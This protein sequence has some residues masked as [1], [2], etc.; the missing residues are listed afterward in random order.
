[1]TYRKVKRDTRRIKNGF[2]IEDNIEFGTD[3]NNTNLFGR[4]Y[5]FG[6][7]DEISQRQS[8]F[9]F[10]KGFAKDPYLVVPYDY[11]SINKK[12]I[13]NP[14]F[15][16]NPNVEKIIPFE[17]GQQLKKF[18]AQKYLHELNLYGRL[19]PFKIKPN[20]FE[21]N[22]NV[23]EEED[24]SE[25]INTNDSLAY[26]EELQRLLASL[27][28]QPPSDTK[29]SNVLMSPDNE[30]DQP[31]KEDLSTK[32]SVV[33]V[34]A[35]VATADNNQVCNETKKQA[36][37]VKVDSV[38]NSMQLASDR[39]IS[40]DVVNSYVHKT[41][42]KFIKYDGRADIHCCDYESD[43]VVIV[44][45]NGEDDDNFNVDEFNNRLRNK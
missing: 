24:F 10:I 31:M 37:K 33:K 1:M 2:G 4:S 34:E 30:V 39:S 20:S 26:V 3:R 32:M 16:L 9:Y 15:R 21:E 8:Y 45:K 11:D 14:T 36:S 38:L 23:K 43:G 12:S 27:S 5:L 25:S 6:K 44:R 22:I 35:A 13:D 7:N 42:R 29:S 18:R 40:L 17:T 19:S 41:S 28:I